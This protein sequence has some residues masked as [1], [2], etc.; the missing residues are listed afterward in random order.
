MIYI[1]LTICWEINVNSQTHEP[2]YN[3]TFIISA[4]ES[5]HLFANPVNLLCKYHYLL[6]NTRTI[7]KFCLIKRTNYTARFLSFH[8]KIDC[9]LGRGVILSADSTFI[10]FDK[11]IH[12]GAR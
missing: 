1:H 2:K 9:F 7:S 3:N 11:P 6:N 5:D 12:D 8:L 10:L 4:P